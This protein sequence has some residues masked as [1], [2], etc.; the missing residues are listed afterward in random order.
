MK[1]F[2]DNRPT[3]RYSNAIID[4]CISRVD[5]SLEKAKPNH[6]IIINDHYPVFWTIT[7]ITLNRH[8]NYFMRKTDWQ[9][10][11]V[12]LQKFQPYWHDQLNLMENTPDAALLL[13]EKFLVALQE[14]CT[15]CHLANKYRP[16]LPQYFVGVL[17]HRKEI[18][19]CYCH[20][21]TD[22][23]KDLLKQINHFIKSEFRATKRATSQKFCGTLEPNKTEQ[24]WRRT[25]TIFKTKTSLTQGFIRADNLIITD[26]N[27]MT[28]HAYN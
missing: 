20:L 14:R 22:D 2:N 16:S 12:S 18:F 28:D 27:Q 5:I 23:L 6:R 26:T 8:E 19:Q 9:L 11:N 10:L 21:K 15:S 3:S 1:V 13:Y 24:F 7:S 4:L 17:K 25:K